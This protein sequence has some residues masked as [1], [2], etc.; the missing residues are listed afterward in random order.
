MLLKL[1]GSLLIMAASSFLGVYFSKECA[2]RAEGTARASETASNVRERN[3][4]FIQHS[5][6]GIYKTVRLL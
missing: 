3:K 6:R 5:D 4:L 2:R 1:I